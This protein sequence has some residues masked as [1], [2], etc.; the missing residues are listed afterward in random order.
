[1][2]CQ[3]DHNK[4]ASP[5]QTEGSIIFARL[6]QCVFVWEPISEYDWT[7]CLRR[8]CGLVKL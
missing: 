2:V 4:A 8:R 3:G 7:V 6:R 5:P 1:M